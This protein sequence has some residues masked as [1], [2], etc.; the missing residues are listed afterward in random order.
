MDA[1]L[2]AGLSYN[3]SLKEFPFLVQQ[4]VAFLLMRGPYAYIGYGEWGMVWPSSVPFPDEI[5][6]N[7][8]GEPVDDYC[9]K[10]D[11]DVFQRRYAKATFQLDCQTWEATIS[12]K[13]V[14]QLS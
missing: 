12:Q 2:L 13:Y 7:D 9:Y 6:K 3:D 14:A 1:P 8:Y 5:W 10:L 4:L 11:H